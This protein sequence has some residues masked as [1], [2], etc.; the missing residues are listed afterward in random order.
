MEGEIDER[1][2]GND[3]DGEREGDRQ[4]VTIWRE[5]WRKILRGERHRRKDA[6]KETEGKK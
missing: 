5:R 2:R 6:G 3:S 1:Y 4:S